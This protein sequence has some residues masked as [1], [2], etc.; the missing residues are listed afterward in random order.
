MTEI[1]IV[2]PARYQSTRFPGKAL[3]DIEGKSMLQHVWE[4]CIQIMDASHVIV[5]TD[6]RRILDHCK[7]KNIQVMITPKNCK[8]G[9]DRLYQVSLTRRA[10]VYINIQG[11]EPLI[12]PDDIKL[13]MN[14]A[15]SN[16]ESVFNAMCPISLDSD[17]FSCNVPKVVARTDGRLLYIS[18]APIPTNKKHGFVSAL[19]QVCIYAFPSD[20]L[21]SYG[22]CI[23]KTELEMIEDIEILRILELGYEVQMVKVS[24]SSIAVEKY[25]HGKGTH[26]AFTRCARC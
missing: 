16:P 22:E 21:R 19:K 2:I 7:E 13:V 11:D 12:S 26:L 6:D 15:Y 8:T 24:G 4:K 25:R 20:V 17:F 9:T 23:R 5:A 3:A 18:R 1:L 14:A 10:D